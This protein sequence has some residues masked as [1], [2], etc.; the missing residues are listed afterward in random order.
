MF[1]ILHFTN[2]TD[3]E[4]TPHLETSTGFQWIK[5]VKGDNTSMSSV[6]AAYGGEVFGKRVYTT[7]TVLSYTHQY[8]D[9]KSTTGV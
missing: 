5:G 1:R 6:A 3:Q 4:E 7:H 9:D 8:T 2:G